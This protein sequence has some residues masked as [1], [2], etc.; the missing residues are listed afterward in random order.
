VLFGHV[1]QEVDSEFQ[2]LRLLSSPSTCIQFTPGA[3]AFT[4]EASAPG[5]R[6]L[7]LRDD[8]TLETGVRRTAEVPAAVDDGTL[9]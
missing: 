8:G 3:D 2:G 5:Y 6:W 7:E 1:H 4:L 9:D